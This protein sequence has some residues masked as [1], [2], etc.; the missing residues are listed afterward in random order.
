[1]SFAGRYIGSSGIDPPSTCERRFRKVR[2]P[3]KVRIMASN[4]EEEPDKPVPPNI[5]AKIRE[6]LSAVLTSEIFVRSPRLSRFLLDAKI[7]RR[8]PLRG[9]QS[10]PRPGVFWLRDR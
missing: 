5:A 6:H 4:A 10:G 3:T 2:R 8:A 7:D 9:P 1:M